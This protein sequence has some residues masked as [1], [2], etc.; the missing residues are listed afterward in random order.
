MLKKYEVY[1][2]TSSAPEAE[3]LARRAP[4]AHAA[5]GLQ[6]L[7]PPPPLPS[8]E[9]PTESFPEERRL[10]RARLMAEM[11][12]VAKALESSAKG[13]ALRAA[14]WESCGACRAWERRTWRERSSAAG[15]PGIPRRRT[16][17]RRLPRFDRISHL[18]TYQ[19]VCIYDMLQ[20][21]T[22]CESVCK[23]YHL[24]LLFRSLQIVF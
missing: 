12:R 16:G 6:Q 18:Q 14:A 8:H 24:I 4:E 1:L 23:S 5:D 19:D 17:K 3:R 7:R 20:Y 21:V 2:D 9:A 15:R 22:S 11:Q 13:E 10:L